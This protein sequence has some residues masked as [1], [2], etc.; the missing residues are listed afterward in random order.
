MVKKVV[1]GRGKQGKQ[2]KRMRG[3]NSV[4]NGV[5]NGAMNGNVVNGKP[6]K[7]SRY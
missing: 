1:S 2:G 5:A 7:W 4:V 3:G 6:R